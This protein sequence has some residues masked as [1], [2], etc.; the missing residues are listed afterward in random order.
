MALRNKYL[1][2][3]VDDF[4]KIMKSSYIAKGGIRSKTDRGRAI[5]QKQL[6]SSDS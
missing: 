3:T 1:C 2:N 4:R 5:E 6:I